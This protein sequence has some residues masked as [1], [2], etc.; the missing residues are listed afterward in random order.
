MLVG[1]VGEGLH[2][3]H[4][5]T[6]RLAR[7]VLHQHL[8][9]DFLVRRFASLLHGR[10]LDQMPPEIRAHRIAH[11]VRRQCEHGLLERR[12][13]HP[14]IDETERTADGRGPG[15]V[16]M[17]LRDVL[18]GLARHDTLPEPGRT[19][20]RLLHGIPASPGLHGY[21]NVGD[22]ALLRGDEA[23]PLGIEQGAKLVVIRL[24]AVRDRAHGDL[25]V[26]QAQPL[27]GE[28]LGPMPFEVRSDLGIRRLGALEV[29]GGN[30]Q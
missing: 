4:V 1:H 6:L 7:L 3:L 21:E 28:V 16:R 27:G 10:H 30:G 23:L 9:A 20:P 18:E 2:A 19:L 14:V 13:H 24:D 26:A 29:G 17:L 22:L 15:I 25:Q 12:V 5:D 11:F 8:V